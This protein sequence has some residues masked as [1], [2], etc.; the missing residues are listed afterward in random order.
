MRCR[1]YGKKLLT[2]LLYMLSYT[3]QD[4][5]ARGGRV[6]CGMG[7]P[8]SIKKVSYR[9]AYRQKQQ[10]HVSIKISIPK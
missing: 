7:L 10:K 8:T 2:G 3:A 9:F 5:L 4:N 6:S 1:G